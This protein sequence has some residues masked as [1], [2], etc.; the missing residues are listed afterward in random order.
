MKTHT[1]N[2]AH[3]FSEWDFV[4]DGVILGA[5][6]RAIT[7]MVA[8]MLS[9]IM[10]SGFPS[11]RWKTDRRVSTVTKVSSTVTHFCCFRVVN[12]IPITVSV[13]CVT[14]SHWSTARD[15]YGWLL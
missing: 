8:G 13:D 2:Q 6:T 15:G 3:R 4:M 5:D 9:K 12:F 14:A 11:D 1:R 10:P 7:G